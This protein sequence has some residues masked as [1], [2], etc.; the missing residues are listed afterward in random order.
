MTLLPMQTPKAFA[1]RLAY[2][3]SRAWLPPAL[4]LLALS[5]LFLIDGSRAHFRGTGGNHVQISAKNMA[6]AENLSIDH[7]FLTF[8]HQNLDTDGKPTYMP[9]GRFPIGSY[10]LIKLAI[11]P[12]GDSLADR[13]RAAR[14]LM[15]LFFAAAAVMSYLSLRRLASSRWIALTATLLAFS[16][17]IALYYG[18]SV[19]SESIID[20]FGVLL[21][22]QGMVIFEQEGRFRQLLLKVCIALLLGWHAY[23]LLLPYIAFG[24]MRGLIKTRSSASTSLPS[25]L[26]QLNRATLSL[27]RSRYLMLGAVALLFGISMLTFNFTSEYLALKGE[28]PLTEIPSFRSMLDRT[29]FSSNVSS[30]RE[31]DLAWLPWRGYLERQ[32]HRIGA[33]TLPYAFSQ[34][35]VDDDRSYARL[36]S[37][38]ILGIS[39]SI[40]SLIGL[41]FVRHHKILLVTLTLSG[42]CWALP[43]RHVTASPYHLYEALHYMGIALTLFSLILLCLRRLSGERIAAALG[44]VSV[45]IFAFSALRMSQLDNS[46]Q[47]AELHKAALADFEVIRN[48]TAG[49]AIMAKAMP[50]FQSMRMLHRYY[51]SGRVVID[52]YQNALSARQPVF[53]VTGTRIDGLASLTPQNQ[54][55]FL[56][57]WDDYHGRIDE[58][59]ESGDR[60]IRSYFDVYLTENALIYV[61]DSCRK[62]DIRSPFFLALFPVNENDLPDKRRQHGFDNLD[63]QFRYGAIRRGEQ[64]ITIIPLPD[65][66]IAR[67][68]TG[69]Y[70]QQPD[71]STA[72]LWEGE[73]TFSRRLTYD[74][75][76]Q[77]NETISQ[78]GEPVIRSDFDVYINDDIL[79][80]VNDDCHEDD[81]GSPFFLAL[82]PVNE[83]DLPDKRRQHGF[84]NL[85]FRFE[86]RAIRRGGRCI[87]IAP[88]PDYDIARIYTGQYIQHADGSFE[89]LWEGEI[90]LTQ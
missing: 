27:M 8:T 65:Y 83:N 80:Y 62:D 75:L 55:I 78:A 82:F 81:G 77:I 85:D 30:I 32:F 67:I 50:E 69:Q 79:I 58:I 10:A 22:F 23:A 2:L 57:E 40:A 13:I 36:R 26:C 35:F 86:E 28:T 25:V 63:S 18:D 48:M 90:H 76:R 43:M 66:D 3:Q 1:F 12:F 61:K 21:V 46:A 7:N 14:I 53:V 11:L 19:S 33:M 9:Y 49:K 64:C 56:Y 70:I 73:F 74:R 39:A 31:G 84:E 34:S 29:G 24:L 44:V 52:R 42:F 54:M 60:I 47:T 87:A 20:T 6:I 89:H 15:L 16:S 41:L 4:L 71:G 37:V 88:L 59:I 72:H 17:P 5:S 51:F 45:L 68:S 38:V